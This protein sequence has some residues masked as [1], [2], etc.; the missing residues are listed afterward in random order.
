MAFE[1]VEYEADAGASSDSSDNMEEM[2]KYVRKWEPN[3]VHEDSPGPH[4]A[5]LLRTSARNIQPAARSLLQRSVSARSVCSK[6]PPVSAE[7]R[8]SS[9]RFGNET[10]NMQPTMPRSK[11]EEDF[12]RTNVC[13]FVQ[14]DAKDHHRKVGRA[15]KALADARKERRERERERER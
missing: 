14:A 13:G 6:A 7:P 2:M 12:A 10:V 9:P 15:L 5:D 1:A 8:D 4:L 3:A 11:S